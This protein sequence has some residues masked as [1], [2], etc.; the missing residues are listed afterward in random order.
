MT[1]RHPA[2]KRRTKKRSKRKRSKLSAKVRHERLRERQFKVSINT[3][4]K[5]A[6]FTQI[7]T[8]HRHFDFD[9]QR[10]EIDNI[11][12][13]ENLVVICED[14]MTSASGLRD[15]LNKTGLFTARLS[16][17]ETQFLEFAFNEFPTLRQAV[18]PKYASTE[19]ELRYVYA[20]FHDI[21]PQHLSAH[22]HL[23]LL[24]RTSLRYFAVLSRTIHRSM[25]YE[26]LKFLK[27]PLANIGLLAGRQAKEYL[28]FVLPEIPSGFPP[29]FKVVTFYMDPQTLLELCYVLRKDSWEDREGLYQRM[30]VRTKIQSM[31]EYLATRDR[32]FV[33]NVIVSLPERTRFHDMDGETVSPSKIRKTD[34]YYVTLPYE[35]NSIGLIDGQ[36]RVFSYHEG[37]D[38]HE[39]N[40]A[41]KR[42]KQQLLVTG[43]VFPKSWS[44]EKRLQFEARLF[45]EIND[46]QTRARGDLKQA[47]EVIVSPFTATA[48]AKSVI[49]GMARNGPLG[50]LLE[51]HYFGEGQIKTTS[52]VSYALRHLV[53]P[54]EGVEDS[55]YKLWGGDKRR[56]ARDAS[57]QRGEYVEFCVNEINRFIDG[58]RVNVKEGFWTAE[59]KSS[60]A[61]STTT[62]NAL[63]YC[64]R[65]LVAANRTGTF[66]HYK[67]GFSNMDVDFRPGAFLYK[68]SH[69]RS[70]GTTFAVLFGVEQ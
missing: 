11:F 67:M 37:A 45:L 32:A 27:V 47:I 63:I 41:A 16:S 4:F 36:H 31:R 24:S 10:G 33:N 15:H 29:E 40:V 34:M 2:G 52:I 39:A 62:I 20:S 25:K 58:F 68:S 57:K 22:R 65:L 21:K 46:K 54:K 53:V 28:G 35:H 56:F 66:E 14:T 44:G 18:D 7:S 49:S 59:R 64:L 19:C 17:R 60:R 61:L 38:Q 48:I 9:G 42:G 70:L 1:A 43:I 51:D 13:Y 26:L 30:L 5:N 3:I 55:L 69:W 8:R 23:T 6:G 50:G 12:V